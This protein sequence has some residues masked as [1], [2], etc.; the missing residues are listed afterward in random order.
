MNQLF[1][2][3]LLIK[4]SERKICKTWVMYKNMNEGKKSVANFSPLMMPNVH[5]SCNLTRQ[6][7][8]I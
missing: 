7:G 2:G 4:S 1:Q 6:I 5:T 8:G 3:I